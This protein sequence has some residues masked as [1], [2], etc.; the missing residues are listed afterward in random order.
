MAQIALIGIGAGAASALLFASVASGSPI[1]ILLFYLAPLPIL[2]AALG[3]SHWAALVAAVAAAAGLAIALGS[4]FFFAFLFGIGLPAW[5]LGY[6]TLLAR[7]GAS[8]DLE[9]YPV[10]RV[11]LWAAILGTLV[12]VAAVPTIGLDEQT[13]HETLRKGF[14]RILR[15]TQN[16]ATQNGDASTDRL[17][18][19]FVRIIPPLAG[20]LST[21]VSLIDLW[22]AG[23]VVKMSGRLTRPWPELSLMRLPPI[24][25]ALLAVG[26]IA[27]FLPGLVGIVAG[28]LVSTL[29]VVYALAGLAVLHFITRGMTSRGLLLGGTY[30]ALIVFGWPVLLMSLFGLVDS[31]VD[32][33]TRF[34]R[35]GGPPGRPST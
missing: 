18:E 1:A 12:V 16:S 26:V 34:G 22:L 25:T 24:A 4:Y 19:F 9:W 14:E 23:K 15:A 3:W 35:S 8:G 17:I 28:V 10:G 6:L 33:R 5:W 13:F 2:I 30:T 31:A 20:T 32:L 21:V 27:C 7:P 29:L 11:V